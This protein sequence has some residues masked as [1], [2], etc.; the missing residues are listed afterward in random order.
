[1]ILAKETDRD[2]MIVHCFILKCLLLNFVLKYIPSYLA[3]Y[4]DQFHFKDV[5]LLF[6]IADI[7]AKKSDQVV[8]C[9]VL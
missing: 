7:Y 3:W 6:S 1:M 5:M 2:R 4:T 9:C 8:S